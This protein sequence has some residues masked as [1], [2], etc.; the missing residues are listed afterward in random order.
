MLR[1]VEDA[2]VAAQEAEREREERGERER[3]GEERL[4]AM[5]ASLAE[6]DA[7]IAALR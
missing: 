7:E 6:R 2:E 3:E 5:S 1:A 4:A